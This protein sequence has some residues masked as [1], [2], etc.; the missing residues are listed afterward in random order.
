MRLVG[1]GLAGLYLLVDSHWDASPL[2][3][4]AM[5]LSGTTLA[6][7]A[8]IL[9]AWAMLYIAGYKTER[10]IMEG[11]FSVCRNPIYFSTVIGV[12][13]IALD[14]CTF[15][16]PLLVLL[17]YLPYI[18]TQINAEEEKL[19]ARHGARFEAYRRRVPRLIPNFA[20]LDEPDE[21]AV[22]PARFRRWLADGLWFVWGIGAVEM[23]DALHDAQ[24]I[25]TL[26]LLY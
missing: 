21:Y 17:L 2:V 11:P 5:L 23:I 7:I 9:R 14:T 10:L 12:L 24:V 15:T 8:V 19:A 26:C 1:V 6:C 25:P 3:G 18:N 16:M 22:Q 20:L 13:G 4:S